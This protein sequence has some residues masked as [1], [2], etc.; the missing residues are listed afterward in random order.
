MWD[1]STYLTIQCK[2]VSPQRLREVKDRLRECGLVFLNCEYKNS[3]VGRKYDT[4]CRDNF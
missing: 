3:K 2:N 1:K 4:T